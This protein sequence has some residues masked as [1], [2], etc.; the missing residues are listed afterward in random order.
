MDKNFKTIKTHRRFSG[1]DY[2]PGQAPLG[3]AT[4]LWLLLMVLLWATNAVVVKI[5]IR[6]IPSCWAAFL[7]FAPALPFI[8]LFVR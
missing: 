4:Y 3:I 2:A 8:F 7:R 5:V 6:D 1:K